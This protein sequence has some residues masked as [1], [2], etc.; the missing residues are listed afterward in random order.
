M[1]IAGVAVKNL[2]KLMENLK[3]VKKIL[4]ETLAAAFKSQFAVPAICDKAPI[5][6]LVE[7][8]VT[9]QQS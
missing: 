7:L 3:D 9:N 8:L 6:S 1:L 4:Q 5:K 2:M